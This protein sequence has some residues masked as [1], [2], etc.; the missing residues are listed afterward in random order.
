MDDSID[1]PESTPLNSILELTQARISKRFR[2]ADTRA[3]ENQ[4]SYR[5]W[6]F[7]ATIAGMIA[8]LLAIVQLLLHATWPT[9][10]E[11][12]FLFFDLSELVAAAVVVVI[13]VIIGFRRELKENW[14]LERHRAEMFRQ[15]RFRFLLNPLCW[16]PDLSEASNSL[17]NQLREV[18]S[19]Y[20]EMMSWVVRATVP[21]VVLSPT[22]MPGEALKTLIAYYRRKRLDVQ[23]EYFDK[24]AKLDHERNLRTRICG[25]FLLFASVAFVLAHVTIS[26]LRSFAIIGSSDLA[27]ADILSLAHKLSLV[28]MGRGSSEANI[29]SLAHELSLVMMGVAAMLPVIAAAVRVYRSANEYARNASRH[30]STYHALNKLSLQLNESTRPDEVF[31]LLGFCEQVLEADHREWMRLM[32]EAE[33]FG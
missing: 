4:N 21:D 24:F 13:V 29:F 1:T 33:W 3:I 12:V 15:L 22:T 27:W 9:L 26:L 17:D 30:R 10:D 20:A 2:D 16:V 23:M 28:M 5:F 8:V 6:A 7:G 25:P 19:N 14:L 31:R 11:R 32:V 18:A